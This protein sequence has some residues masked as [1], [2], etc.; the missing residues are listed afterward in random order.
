M[1]ARNF[2][3][4]LF[5]VTFVVVCGVAFRM[6]ADDDKVVPAAVVAEQTKLKKL[7]PEFSK[8]MHAYDEATRAAYE[9]D[10][11][12]YEQMIQVL[13]ELR[14]AELQFADTAKDRIAVLEKMV[15]KAKR[16]ETKIEALYQ[17]GARGGEA[18]KYAHAKAVRLQAEIDLSRERIASLSDE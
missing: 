11:V 7:V 13:R 2:L 17:A 9:T 5:G 3:R 4:I 10:T 15:Q 1:F 12:P 8:A 16:L 18:E 6:P 14:D